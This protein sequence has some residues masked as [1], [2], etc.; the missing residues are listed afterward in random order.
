M[1]TRRH[2]LFLTPLLCVLGGCSSTLDRLENINQQPP[3]SRSDNPQVRADYKPMSWPLPE[4]TPPDTRYANSLW[5]PGARTFFRDQRA[6]RV[7]DILKIH[8][9]ID[10][11]AEV[12]NETERKRDSG[13]DIAAPEVFGLQKLLGTAADDPTLFDI[14]GKSNNKGTGNIKRKE[15]IETDIAAVVTQVLPNGNFVIHGSQEIRINFEIREVSISGIVRPE[16]IDS[17]NT[18]DS[19][20]VAEARVV[21]GGRGQLTDVQQPRWGSQAVDIL[22][23]F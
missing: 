22:S 9:E 11:K 17:S 8:I 5:Q 3:L 13:E 20:Q 1:M 4:P 15:K 2:Y 16:D 12:D 23:P 18:V 7:G 19:T 10:D 21:Y 14:T 6:A